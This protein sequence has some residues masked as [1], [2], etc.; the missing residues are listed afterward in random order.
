[1]EATKAQTPATAKE[2]QLFIPIYIVSSQRQEGWNHEGVE[3][4]IALNPSVTRRWDITVD[5]YFEKLY[6]SIGLKI[7]RVFRSH[8]RVPNIMYLEEFPIMT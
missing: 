3:V 8:S 5:V 6:R 2:R 7:S 4:I 1:M